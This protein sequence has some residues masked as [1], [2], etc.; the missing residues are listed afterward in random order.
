V[1][2]G[3]SFPS[4]DELREFVRSRIVPL[5]AIDRGSVEILH[6]DPASGSV[7]LRYSRACA[8]C[9]GLAVTHGSLV[10]PLL[11]RA[12]PA[13]TSVEATIEGE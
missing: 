10:A 1:A 3:K 4:A 12:F 9:P 13:V 8:G 7:T 2:E 5:V 11:T 6:A